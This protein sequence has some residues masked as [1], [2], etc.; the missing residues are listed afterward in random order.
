MTPSESGKYS[1]SV[2]RTILHRERS[3]LGKGWYGVTNGMRLPQ[4]RDEYMEHWVWACWQYSGM[5]VGVIM[6]SC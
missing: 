5:L 1:A 4:G 3:P 6:V 2:C